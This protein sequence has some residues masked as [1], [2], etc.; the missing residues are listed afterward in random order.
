ML[1]KMSGLDPFSRKPV[2]H[3]YPLSFIQLTL[4]LLNVFVE[5]MQTHTHLKLIEVTL[6]CKII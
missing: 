3:F 1:T 2:F 5:F 6:V 4:P